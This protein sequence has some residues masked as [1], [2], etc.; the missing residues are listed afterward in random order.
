V[1]RR[2]EAGA[3]ND[4]GGVEELAGE[5]GLSPR[6]LAVPCAKELGVSPVALAQTHRL[7]FAKQ[8]LTETRLPII[9]V[10]FASGFA[11]V[12]RFNGLF[13]SHYRLTPSQLRREKGRFGERGIDPAQPLL[14]AGRSPG[15][16][17]CAF[18]PTGPLPASNAW[19]VTATCERLRWAN[20]RAGSA[21]SR[22][23]GETCCQWKCPRRSCRRCRRCWRGC[24][25]CLIWTP[26]P[27]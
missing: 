26:G 10:A 8:L 16:S 13:R 25:T 15:P 18:S 14:P 11:S 3:L 1:A 24:G 20:T 27:T 19:P 6:Q 7:L 23:R 4:G 5:F 2:I 17:C 21:S 9:Q 22:W 12:R